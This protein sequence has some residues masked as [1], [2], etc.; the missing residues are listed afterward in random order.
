[1]RRTLPFLLAAA[2]VA[3]VTPSLG[4]VGGSIANEDQYPWTAA[5]YTGTSPSGGQFCGGTLVA[6]AVVVT[7]AH[8]V[9]A[10]LSNTAADLP[11]DPF[12]MIDPVGLR[13]KV[14]VGSRHLSATRGEHRYVSRVN[15]HPSQSMDIAV[16]QLESKVQTEPIGFLTSSSDPAL[17]AP[18]VV[19][20]ITGW[21]ATS[22]G[23]SGSTLL[24]HAQVPII[25]DSNCR[26]SYGSSMNPTYEICAGYPQGGTDSCQ[27]DSGGPLVVQRPNGSW[28][29]AGATSWGDGCARP[30]APGV[31][32]EMRAAAA[33]ISNYV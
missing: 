20:T 25:S 28:V 10:L 12:R 24:R 1:M 11:Q 19:A 8:C 14:M 3:S 16:L 15:R 5:V 6:P 4:I 29:L 27:G 18:G 31:Y 30:D 22:E 33:F 7:A 13:L 17:D 23:G 2:L 21:G 9:N 32:A 26:A